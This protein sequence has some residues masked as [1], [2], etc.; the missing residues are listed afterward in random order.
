MRINFDCK[1]LNEKY[2]NRLRERATVSCRVPIWSRQK[3]PNLLTLLE[4]QAL[5]LLV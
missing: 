2:L 3:L 5:E 4:P 1:I